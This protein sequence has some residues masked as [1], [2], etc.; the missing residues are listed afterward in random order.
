LNQRHFP[1]G[2]TPVGGRREIAGRSALY[3]VEA[4]EA[5][6][7]TIATGI[8]A[9][10]IQDYM[11]LLS[12]IAQD[13][14]LVESVRKFEDLEI[15][16][17][18]RRYVGDSTRTEVSQTRSR[19]AGARARRA[20][21]LAELRNART[22]L[23]STTGFL[24]DSS[25]LPSEAQTPVT[26]D[27]ET[28]KRLARQESPSLRAEKLGTLSAGLNLRSENRQHLP[29]VTLTANASAAGRKTQPL[30]NLIRLGMIHPYDTRSFTCTP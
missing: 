23:Y 21:G 3:T 2:S 24:I 30:Y 11:S 25:L 16:M 6:Y 26:H 15:L 8:A 17:Q 9:E 18:A 12:A 13:R 1:F 7:E 22:R 28:L 5:R 27:L 20:A 4:S 14:A 29:T 19:L 10:I